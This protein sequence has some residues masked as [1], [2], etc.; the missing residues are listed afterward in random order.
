MKL[1]QSQVSMT[2]VNAIFGIFPNSLWNFNQIRMKEDEFLG[3]PNQKTLNF[4][5]F[6]AS[7]IYLRNVVQSNVFS[8]KTLY[9]LFSPREPWPWRPWNIVPSRVEGVRE[10]MVGISV[11]EDFYLLFW[12]PV[13]RPNCPK[14]DEMTVYNWIVLY[15]NIFVLFHLYWNSKVLTYVVAHS[16]L[17]SDKIHKYVGQE[18]SGRMFNELVLDH[19]S[20]YMRT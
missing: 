1:P 13:F 6:W 18:P 8:Y 9:S 12:N 3:T 15:V 16:E 17:G 4:M 11:V 20:E 7:Y 5:H 10:I 14:L 2:S 19:N